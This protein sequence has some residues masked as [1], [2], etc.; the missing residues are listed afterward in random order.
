MKIIFDNKEQKE[1]FLR[2]FSEEQSTDFCPS[3]FGMNEATDG[4]GIASC[5]R[6]CWEQAVELI[7]EER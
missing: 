5:C 2:I 1:T 3:N 4:C 6:E 7:V